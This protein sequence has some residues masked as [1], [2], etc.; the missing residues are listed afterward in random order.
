MCGVDG[1]ADSWPEDGCWSWLKPNDSDFSV[2]MMKVNLC[3]LCCWCSWSMGH[4]GLVWFSFLML[5]SGLGI[6][7]DRK[8]LVCFSFC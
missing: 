6:K 5:A 7:T 4:V 1:G 3:L 2:V 8:N